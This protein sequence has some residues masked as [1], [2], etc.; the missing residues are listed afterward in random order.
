MI[1]QWISCNVEAWR[2]DTYA[3][4]AFIRAHPKWKLFSRAA[5][6]DAMRAVVRVQTANRDTFNTAMGGMRGM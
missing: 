1:R 3:I 2:S 5:R 6:K 4:K